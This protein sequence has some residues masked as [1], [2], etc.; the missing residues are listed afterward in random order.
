MN[1]ISAIAV[2]I[3]LLCFSVGLRASES[4][5]C[6]PVTHYGVKGCEI[7][8]GQTCPTGYHRQVVDPP[9]PMMKAPS[10]LMCVADEKPAKKPSKGPSKSEASSPNE[11]L[12]GGVN[13]MGK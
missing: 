8:A 3:G 10:V 11:S 13:I 5:S 4:S 6:K 9:N 7:L 1:R 12:K 2:S